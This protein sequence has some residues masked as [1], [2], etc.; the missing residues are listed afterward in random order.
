[1]TQ[2]Y[3]IET[4]QQAK[5]YEDLKVMADVPRFHLRNCPEKTAMVFEGRQTSYR[6]FD[7]H[8]SQLANAMIKEDVA[9]QKRVAYLDVNTDHFF[10]LLFGCGKANTVMCA[11]NWR[12]APPEVEYIVNDAE[13]ELLFVG[14]R[15]FG[16]VEAIKE[17][18]PSVKKVIALSGQHSEWESIDS[19]R[20]KQ[21]NE[22]PN[23]PVQESDIAIQMYTS[24][25]TGHP[26][27][28]QISNAALFASSV[29]GSDDVEW[30]VWSPEDVSL[31]AMP[32]FHVGGSRWGVMGLIPGC[33]NVIIPEFD[34]SAV[35]QIIQEY[36]VS[37]IFM[38]PAAMQFVLAMPQARETDYSSIDYILYGASPIPLE[39]LKEAIDVFQCGFV[40]LYGMTETAGSATFLPPRDHSVEG[41]ER[42]KSAGKPLPFVDVCIKDNLGDRLAPREVGEICIKSPSN[43]S[44]YWKL[45][46]ATDKT[47]IDG[48]IHTGDAGYMD[49]DGYV[50]VYDRIKDMIVSG[51][52]NIYPAEIESVMFG[53]PAVADVAVIGVP[54]DKWGESVKGVVVLKEGA[55]ATAEEILSFTRE[56]I[57]GFKIPKSIDFIA[58]LPRNPSGKLLKRELRAPYWEGR[59]RQVN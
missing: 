16:I 36:R 52:E 22:D 56:K 37:K 43:M 28:V 45:P 13:A 32:C 7:L 46:E 42:M 54:D 29:D 26:K 44:G 33:L 40:Q 4:L 3:N 38:V 57:A 23:I 53:H 2:Y 11:V 5:T 8:T 30:N 6:D 9:E 48:W 39:L 49:E 12:L 15:F 59:D 50:Y 27:G 25:T 51:G 20:D 41:N 21:S 58:E 55:E 18:L 31:V 34:P 1:M 14:E 24:G 47:M 35:L 10:E 17:K 19:W